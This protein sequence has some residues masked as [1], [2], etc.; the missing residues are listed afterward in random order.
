MLAFDALAGHVDKLSR[1]DKLERCWS[2]A[3]AAQG[4]KKSIENWTRQY[5]DRS[6]VDGTTSSRLETFSQLGKTKKR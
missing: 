3:V 5:E 2:S 6:E 4:E 1:V